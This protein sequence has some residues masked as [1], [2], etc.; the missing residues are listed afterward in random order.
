MKALQFIKNLFRKEISKEDFTVEYMQYLIESGHIAELDNCVIC[1]QKTKYT[2]DI[3]ID[4]RKNYIEGVGQLCN[5]CFY[6]YS[7]SE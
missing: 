4:K 6:K 3:S 5:D 1:K 7:E 2:K